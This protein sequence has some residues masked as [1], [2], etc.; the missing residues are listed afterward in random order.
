MN[1]LELIKDT[2][3]QKLQKM[4]V[5][6]TV[7]FIDFDTEKEITIFCTHAELVEDDG[8]IWI[9]FTD[10]KNCIHQTYGQGTDIWFEVKN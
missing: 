1:L 8:N 6:H 4:C 5:D 7:K 9:E 10:D 2:V 3:N